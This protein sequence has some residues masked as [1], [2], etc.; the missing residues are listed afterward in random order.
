VRKK[1][2]HRKKATNKRR[3]TKSTNGERKDEKLRRSGW[4]YEKNENE[5]TKR[6]ENTKNAKDEKAKCAEDQEGSAMSIQKHYAWSGYGQCPNASLRNKYLRRN[7]VPDSLITRSTPPATIN[8]CEPVTATGAQPLRHSPLELNRS[9][10]YR[11]VS[12][13][14][15][16][17]VSPSTYT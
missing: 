4:R 14:T 7:E 5:P 10:T 13:L 6:A 11:P 16:F 8:L 2:R 17:H 12:Q 9:S 3:R 1:I 15:Y